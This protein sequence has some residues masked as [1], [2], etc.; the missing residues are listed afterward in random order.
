MLVMATGRLLTVCLAEPPLV[1]EPSS[2]V[3]NSYLHIL[4][5]WPSINS[6]TTEFK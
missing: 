6:I 1:R 4:Q 5:A 2:T 3:I